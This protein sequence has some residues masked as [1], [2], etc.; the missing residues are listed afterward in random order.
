ML[1]FVTC[2]HI[3]LYSSVG[4]KG[5]LS[6]IEKNS[7]TYPMQLLECIVHLFKEHGRG[8]EKKVGYHY[9]LKDMA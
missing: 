9:F 8:L 5:F 4:L 3:V 2:I 7:P 1:P 6:G